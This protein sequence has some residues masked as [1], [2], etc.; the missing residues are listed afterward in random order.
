MHTR[1]TLLD[2]IDDELLRAP[3]TYDLVL[4]AVHERWRMRPPAF[5]PGKIDP[6]RV[7]QQGR[8]ELV[9]SAVRALRQSALYEAKS[10]STITTTS[11][12]GAALHSRSE[13]SLIDEGDVEVDI[14]INRCIE[15]I[16]VSAEAELRT[17]QTFTSALVDDVN[18]S[19]DTNP[20]RAECMVRALWSGVQTLPLSN[21]S[22]ARLMHDAAEPLAALL[23]KAYAAACHRLEDQGVT[24]ATH[25][26][27]VVG[28]RTGWG[29][30]LNRLRLPEDLN[31]LRDSMPAPLDALPP[32]HGPAGYTEA[33]H[34]GLHVQAP[35]RSG[36]KAD[37]QLIE[38]LARLFDTLQKDTQLAPDTASLIQ[39]LEPSVLRMALVDPKL[40]D[41]YDHPAWQFMNQL[42]FD[43]D[44]CAPSQRLRL[45]GLGRNLVD[46]L[47]ASPQVE[48]ASFVWALERLG[49]AQRHA[50]LLATQAAAHDIER[51]QAAAPAEAWTP[52]NRV[53]L[54]ISN[55]DTVPADLMIDAPAGSF[56]AD[57]GLPDGLSPGTRIRAYLQGSWR[58]LQSLWQD[59][60]GEYVLMVEHA[61]D[62][63][64]ALRQRALTRLMNEGLAHPLKVRSLVRRAAEIVL[65]KL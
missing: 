44:F 49:A 1:P 35:Q 6:S 39:R 40:L 37:P 32:V 5:E 63:R 58:N 53:P 48:A 20:F 59:N 23:R 22:K 19:R 10:G 33:L 47:A 45:L 36:N 16:R 42:A 62:R 17:L 8:T 65:R 64:W 61:H 43:I 14:E 24:Q 2:F 28:S 27:I 31:V 21:P 7:L 29:A 30:E 12:P 34:T 3:M 41:A 11:F 57:N 56:H 13:L 4:D 18:I 9:A 15:A 54:D 50:L 52:S 55:L 38:L 25:R 60:A 51:L 46:H 26:T